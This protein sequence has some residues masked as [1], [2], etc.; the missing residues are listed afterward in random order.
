[1]VDFKKP[2]SRKRVTLSEQALEDVRFLREAVERNTQVTTLSP[3]GLLVSGIAGITAALVSLLPGTEH[4]A[5]VLLP[6]QITAFLTVWA[7]A[8]ALA[9]AAN[10]I[11]MR[12]RSHRQGASFRSS[13][14]RRML[15]SLTAPLTAG[16]VFSLWT[17]FFAPG[18]W[19]LA[20]VWL[21]FYGLALLAAA[22]YTIGAVRILGWSTLLASGVLLAL[23]PGIGQHGAAI[24]LGVVFGGGHLLLAVHVGG[25][26][27]W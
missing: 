20:T 27:G 19:T 21:G 5:L 15:A 11:G 17:L 16:A 3:G 6:S 4:A 13:A 22:A 18:A 1:M 26:Y 2:P 9:V 23:G 10:L 25:R 7:G 24:A 8:L 12:V 14:F